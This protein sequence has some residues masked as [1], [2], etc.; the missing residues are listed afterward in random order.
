MAA[1]MDFFSSVARV[2]LRSGRKSLPSIVVRAK[3]ERFAGDA[4]QGT[5]S[6]PFSSKRDRER[7]EASLSHWLRRLKKVNL[8][9]NMH[10]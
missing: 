8:S 9:H 10:P 1:L 7:S 4:I 5:L 3:G 6:L 2:L